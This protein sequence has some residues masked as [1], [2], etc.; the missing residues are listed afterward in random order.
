MR[1]L[2]ILAILKGRRKNFPLFNEGGGGPGKVLHCLE[3]GGGFK[4]LDR[5]F[6][7]L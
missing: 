7:I 1:Y 2:E 4:V 6:P 5:E 3:G